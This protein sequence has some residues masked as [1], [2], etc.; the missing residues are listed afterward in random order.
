MATTWET[1]FIHRQMSSNN[2][3]IKT[4]FAKSFGN[5]LDFVVVVFIIPV[6]VCLFTL[7]SVCV[8]SVW[9]Y[10]GE[11]ICLQGPK[12][13]KG[14]YVTVA[15]GGCKSP[16]MMLGTKPGFPRKAASVPKHWAVLTI[17]NG[18]TAIRCPEKVWLS[19]GV[20]T[21]LDSSKHRQ[22]RRWAERLQTSPWSGRETWLEQGGELGMVPRWCHEKKSRLRSLVG[23]EELGKQYS[24]VGS[25]H[26]Y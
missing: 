21:S 5:F 13:V 3:R 16:H 1:L 10:T 4:V 17:L 19:P 12:E 15:N 20:I 2:W 7:I 18:A 24:L 22:N 9:V 8:V 6:C 11:C 14:S 23:M 26:I 25:M